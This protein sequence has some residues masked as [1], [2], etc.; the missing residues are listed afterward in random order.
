LFRGAGIMGSQCKG[1]T[2]SGA[3]CKMT[4]VF[5]NGFCR[6]HQN[7]YT[8]ENKSDTENKSSENIDTF[9]TN[10]NQQNEPPANHHRYFTK[11]KISSH[12]IPIGTKFILCTIILIT[13]F[14]WLSK[15]L[16]KINPV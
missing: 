15:K 12:R 11:R 1:V 10:S 3:Q 14:S 5:P 16:I 13:V 9:K 2:K 6:V 4:G 7:Q 8:I